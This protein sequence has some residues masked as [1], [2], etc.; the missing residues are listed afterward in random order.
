[1]KNFLI[2]LFAGLL[3]G[4]YATAQ[5]NKKIVW[6]A[7]KAEFVDGTGNVQDTKEVAVIL[8]TSDKSITII[9]NDE[10][11]DSLHGPV[12]DIQ[13]D[14]KEPVKTGKIT[15]SGELGDRSGE[16]NKCTLVIEARDSKI[17]ILLTVDRPDGEKKYIRIPI[18]SYKEEK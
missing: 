10:P 3:A 2:L 13:C 4:A 12:K 8:H 17:I 6:T 9:H 16:T 5:C 18:D 15:L 14:W 7:S 11:A 1:M